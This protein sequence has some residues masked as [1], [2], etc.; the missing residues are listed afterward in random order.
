MARLRIVTYD[1]TSEAGNIQL[2][3]AIQADGT[4]SSAA[5]YKVMRSAPDLP[6]DPLGNRG[7][8]GL[9]GC[10]TSRVLAHK[11]IDSR[12]ASS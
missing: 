1:V 9:K 6:V 10:F 5:F 4:M 11:G 12:I 2:N 7:L 8:T 3:M